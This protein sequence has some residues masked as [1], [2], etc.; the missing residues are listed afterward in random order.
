MVQH[1]VQYTT[2]FFS[3]IIKGRNNKQAEDINARWVETIA[4]SI[5]MFQNLIIHALQRMYI[6]YN[7]PFA[8]LIGFKSPKFE[9]WTEFSG[10]FVIPSKFMNCSERQ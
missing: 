2:C 9:T 4:L 8:S 10:S 7:D 6:L 1:V 5:R 3:T